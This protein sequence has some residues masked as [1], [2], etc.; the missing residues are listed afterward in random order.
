MSGLRCG[1]A[2]VVLLAGAGAGSAVDPGDLLKFSPIQA[3]SA[4]VINSAGILLSPRAVKDGWAKIDRTEALAGAVP[5]NPHLERVIVLKEI[6]PGAPAAGPTY[7]LAYAKRPVDVDRLATASGGRQVTIGEEPAVLT[8]N[9]T[10]LIPLDKELF[11]VA[12][13]ENRQDVSR[14]VRLAKTAKASPLALYVNGVVRN[15]G[16]LHH[17]VLALD[18]DDLFDQDHAGVIVAASKTLAADTDAAAGIQKFLAG[19][20]GVLMTVDFKADG[21]AVLLRFDSKAA[22]AKV[23]PEAFKAFILETLERHGAAL[24]DLPTA[25]V[26]AKE[27]SV[28]FRFRLSDEELAQ[29][30]AL[31]LPPLPNLSSVTIPVAPAG[32]TPVKSTQYVQAVNQIVDDLKKQ[33]KRAR[34]YEKTALWYDTSANRIETLSVLNVDP[35]GTEYGAETAGR[36]RAIGDSLRGVPVQVNRLENKVYGFTTYQ[37]GAYWAGRG[38]GGL[39]A[40]PYT[41]TNVVSIREQQAAAVE[42]DRENRAKLWE[43]I[44]QLRATTR[45][46][47]AEKYKVDVEAKKR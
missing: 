8:P 11:G 30:M 15:Y 13:A 28:S 2:A 3:N 35:L 42:R 25:A 33:T 39:T 12:W 14:W 10:Y 37:G 31:F 44:D 24:E 43:A 21:L 26:E 9:Q 5:V 46:Q 34:D 22:T 40:T 29:I 19:L 4:V 7:A 18:V 23:K 6:R 1:L 16:P 36:L 38:R 41:Q 45:S 17:V 20:R 32:P 47:L 27:G